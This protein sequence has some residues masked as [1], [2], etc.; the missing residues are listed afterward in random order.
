[1]VPEEYDDQCERRAG[2]Q[3]GRHEDHNGPTKVP[4]RST[5]WGHAPTAPP[6]PGRIDRQAGA[7]GHGDGGWLLTRSESVGHLSRALR[8][9]LGEVLIGLDDDLRIA[10]RLAIGAGLPQVLFKERIV[11]GA[12]PFVDRLSGRSRR[13]EVALGE[14]ADL[15]LLGEYCARH[16][17]LIAPAQVI[18]AP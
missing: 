13:N 3:S 18:F 1:L 4:A 14:R 10:G 9:E 12:C 5:L 16:L 7:S 2:E 8:H 6:D 15:V 11:C 17:I